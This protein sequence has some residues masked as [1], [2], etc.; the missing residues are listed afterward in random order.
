MYY[1]DFESSL[2]ALINGVNVL[3]GS[4]ALRKACYE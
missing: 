4:A 1:F 3:K 2:A